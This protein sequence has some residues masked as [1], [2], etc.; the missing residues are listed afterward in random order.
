MQKK[1]NLDRV[2]PAHVD[3]LQQHLVAQ[4]SVPVSCVRL[5]STATWDIRCAN[6]VDLVLQTTIPMHQRHAQIVL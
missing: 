5:G 2:I 6:S 4:A 3:A 1:G